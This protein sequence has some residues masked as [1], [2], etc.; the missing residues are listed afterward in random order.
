MVDRVAEEEDGGED[1]RDAGDPGE[2]LDADEGLE[3]ELRSRGLRLSCGRGIGS[4]SRVEGESRARARA[5]ACSWVRVLREEWRRPVRVRGWDALR[6]GGR[7]RRRRRLAAQ[8]AHLLLK[9]AHVLVGARA[10]IVEL[11]LEP[12]EF[13]PEIDDGEEGDDG[14]DDDEHQHA[15]APCCDDSDVDDFRRYL[16][17]SPAASDAL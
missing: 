11:V 3:V 8:V 13:P 1:E 10:E 16:G 17:P 7:L 9:P 6:F 4:G 14:E 15:R 5:R 12:P 2:E